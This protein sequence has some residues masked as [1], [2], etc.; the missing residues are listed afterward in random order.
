MDILD[1]FE[2][3]FFKPT[4]T[5]KEFKFSYE[6]L[7]NFF[8]RL[9]YGKV[10]E[11]FGKEASGKTTFLYYI[12]NSLKLNTLLIDTEYSF[13]INY[14]KKKMNLDNILITQENNISK[15]EKILNKINNIDVICIDSLTALNYKNFNEIEN[16]IQKLK[17][18]IRDKEII[19]FITNQMRS[20]IISK[21]DVAFGSK[22]MKGSYRTRIQTQKFKNQNNFIIKAINLNQQQKTITIEC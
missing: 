13:D 5:I 16:F 18:L 1:N 10:I 3:N 17:N 21:T 2:R 9:C 15:I 12:L 8:D 20:K 6:P 4:K 7:N 14:A 11:I 22:Q 19:I